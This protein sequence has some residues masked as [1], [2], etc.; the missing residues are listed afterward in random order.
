MKTGRGSNPRSL[1]LAWGN[2]SRG[3]DALGPLLAERV[4]Q[5]LEEHP[6]SSIEVLEDFQLQVEHS[7]DLEDRDLV[8][9]MD[10]SASCA[11][12]FTFTKQGPVRDESY[13]THALTPGALLEVFQKLHP[14]KRIPEA[15]LLLVRGQAFELGEPLSGLAGEY[16][17]AAWGFL[18]QRLK[19]MDPES[20]V[21]S[22][23]PPLE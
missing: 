11:P 17:E 12:P 1:I 7:L 9:F 19:Q 22:M 18:A 13:S 5:F 4:R 8:L 2:P 23:V 14:A 6:S 21:A 3:D 16:L 15:F 10:A 20:W